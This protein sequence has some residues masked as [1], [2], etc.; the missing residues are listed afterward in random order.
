[1]MWF[2]ARD[3]AFDRPFRADE[4]A[5]MMRRMGV[6]SSPSGREPQASG[7]GPAL[8]PLFPDVDQRFESMLRFM[9]GLMFIEVSAFHVFVWAERLLDDPTLCAGDGAAGDLVRFIRG[10]ETP[11]VEYLRT[12]ITEVRDRTVR[13]DDGKEIAG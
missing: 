10:D 13:T 4:T 11:H 7:G 12:A 9:V 3:I 2:A 1:E 6:P 5:E 8:E